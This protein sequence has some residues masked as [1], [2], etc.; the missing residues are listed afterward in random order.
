M[1]RLDDCVLPARMGVHVD[2]DGVSVAVWSRHAE[3]ID[4][5]VFDAAGEREI[6]RFRL[7]GRTGDVRHGRLPDAGPGLVYGLRAHGPYAPLD[8]H[9]FNANK[10]L[11]DPCAR[12]LVGRF[13]WH[14]AVLGH[15]AGHP[16]G[17]R[18]FD[19][20]D[21]APFVPKAR[22]PGALR[23]AGE[24]PPKP[25]RPWPETVL[26][27]AHVR[28]FSM[29]NPAVPAALRGTIAGLAHPASIAHLERLGVTAVELLPVAAWLD[30]LHLVNRGFP[31]YW[32][33]NPI[34]FFAMQPALAGPRGLAAMVDAVDAL[35]EA[36]IEVILDVVFNHTGE[37]DERG[38]TLSLRGL[39]N[40]SYYLPDPGRP[41][42]YRNLSGCGNT[43]A[44]HD[45]AVGALIVEA[46]RFW[47]GE[48]GVDGFRFDLAGAIA[49]DAH[50]R[51][52]PHLPW[53][54]ALHEDPVLSRCKLVAEGWDCEGHFVGGFPPGWS[55]W[56]DR[57]RDDVRRFWLGRA[58]GV[59]ALATRLAGSSDLFGS[60]GR[61]P[62]ASID[63]V[64]AHDGFTLA[65]TVSFRHKRN[66]A[67]GEDDRD[68]H[69]HEIA[70]DDGPDGLADDPS[71]TRRRAR[72][73][74]AMLAT[75]MLSRGVPMLRAGDEFGATQ[76]GNNNAYCQDGPLTWIAWPDETGHLDGPPAVAGA[77]L[78]PL[79]A[80]LARL[81]AAHP[82]LRGGHFLHGHPSSDA[83][84][85]HDVTWLDEHAE[86]L[87]AGHWHD[88]HRRVLAL[89]LDAGVPRPGAAHDRLW[90]ALVAADGPIPLRLPDIP[91]PDGWTLLLDTAETSPRLAIG[92]DRT[93]IAQ[94]P[95]VIVC[96]AGDAARAER[97]R[98]RDGL[99]PVTL[100]SAQSPEPAIERV[101]ADDDPPA[102]LALAPV[103][104]A[105]AGPPTTRPVRSIAIEARTGEDGRRLVRHRIVLPG[106]LPPGAYS[107]RPVAAE[108]AGERTPAQATPSATDRTAADRTAA[109]RAAADRATADRAALDEAVD[110]R[111]A[112][113]LLAAPQRCWLP[114]ELQRPQGA[115][116]LSVQLYGLQGARTWGIGDYE[117]LGDLGERAGGIGAAGLLVSP[118]H[119]SCL[120]WPDRGSPY[121]PS[122]RLALAPLF[123]GLPRAAE[124][125]ATPLF[126]AWVGR[127][128]TRAA[129]E[130]VRAGPCID[131]A[132]V[133][134]L[135]RSGFE[136][137]WRDFQ[138][139][140]D[141]AGT[142]AAAREFEAWRAV[143]APRL[144]P[145]L[146]FEALAEHHGVADRRA[147]PQGFAHPDDAGTLAF[148]RAHT[149]RIAFHA[150][151]QWL[152]QRQ[153]REA[154]DRCRAAGATI[155]P[156]T[157]LAVGAD[158]AGADT[159]SRP[160]LVADDHEI[161]APPDAF[162]AEGQAWGLPPWR[163]EALAD[164]GLAPLAELLRATMAGAGGLRIDHVMALE[165]LFWVP[166]GRRPADG[167]YVRYPLEDLLR[168]V[169]TESH[170]RRC[171]VIGED[172][173]TV[174]PGLRERLATAAVLSY[175]VAWFER[176]ADG[177]LADPEALPPLAA[178]CASTHDL[179]TIDG[180]VEGLDIDER[181]ARGLLDAAGAAR[182]RAE[183]R[184]DLARIE[185]GLERAG[186]R[187][188]DLCDRLHRWLAA[189]RARLAIVQLEDV[190]GLRRQPNL[191]G[192]PDEAP[193]WRQRLPHPVDALVRLPR[194]RR[195][196]TI[197][198]SRRARG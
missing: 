166:R 193:N 177:T 92:A 56:N 182:Q 179:P 190:A 138:A 187:G 66:H 70:G 43:L 189:S 140:A 121:S 51:F 143:L 94:G 128:D 9:R 178:V 81:R 124:G 154:G 165:R 114:A 19:T 50:G 12:E 148:E 90:I 16:D 29:R 58:H 185:A 75:L 176:A 134:A 133:S 195:L 10:L 25:G 113:R 157:D 23:P 53:L 74:R 101:G 48:V 35:H 175:K 8:G 103:D 89:Q 88:G 37:G 38:P 164:A 32:G 139:T 40:A 150:F 181:E 62:S 65:D 69:A 31:N 52:D 18:S 36:G 55:E 72:R 86:P 47:A 7:P 41:G 136:H 174:R 116:A 153:W 83:E 147:W 91:H 151:L 64:T 119:A 76:H 14:D 180:W 87:H 167:A 57:Y 115:W 102:A 125:F 98:W 127:A 79:L 61:G 168:V 110:A 149:D 106:P 54:R 198:A 111:P 4:L 197:F 49:R 95:A 17:T 129:I 108:A 188:D 112:A 63:Y 194:W 68:G 152:A 6:G 118:L 131:L 196:A 135:K 169:A 173:G 42:G 158:P 39:D 93:W 1:N 44:A 137:L 156:I 170:A 183:R 104:G 34:A 145:H 117:V 80:T 105:T 96:A 160:G 132:A 142:R 2:G 3:A 155:G 85:L 192:T 73:M 15:V 24:R 30:E 107:I 77:D 71:V 171:L 144:R 21:S 191:P 59:G 28:G 46:L 20:R 172:L 99:P 163:P 130:A 120:G 84:R 11:L 100:V 82:A 161:G 184:D 186:L 126:D 122:S 67:N 78:R 141:T 13:R 33:Y 123:I 97:A 60:P 27:E 146:L 5:C 45:P 159:W 109:D 26:Y 162:A 22:V